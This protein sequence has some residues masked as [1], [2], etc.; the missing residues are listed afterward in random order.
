MIASFTNFDERPAE[1][2]VRGKLLNSNGKIVLNDQTV[3][4]F[5]GGILEPIAD[6]PGK[7]ETVNKMTVAPL[8]VSILP[9]WLHR[10]LTLTCYQLMSP[11]L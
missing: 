7:L 1:L 5:E 11:W 2:E 6:Q 8:G 9:V 4:R 3:A 10:S